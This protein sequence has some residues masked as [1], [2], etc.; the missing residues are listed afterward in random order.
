MHNNLTRRVVSA[1]Y[2]S[3]YAIDYSL[4]VCLGLFA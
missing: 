4:T 2:L 1:L 3:A